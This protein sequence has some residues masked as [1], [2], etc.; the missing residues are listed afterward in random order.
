MRLVNYTYGLIDTI[1][2][3]MNTRYTMCV[4]Y[5]MQSNRIS[6]SLFAQCLSLFISTAYSYIYDIFDESKSKLLNVCMRVYGESRL[7]SR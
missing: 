3:H 6:E 4:C 5:L 2:N 7:K 1:E